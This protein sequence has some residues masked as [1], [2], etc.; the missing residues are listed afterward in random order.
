MSWVAVV[1]LAGGVAAAVGHL[2][3]RA[4]AFL[5]PLLAGVAVATGVVDGAPAR[6]AL[7][8]LIEPLSFV[9]LAVPLAV[10]LDAAG[11][12]DAVARRLPARSTALGLWVLGAA[13]VALVNLDAAV[14]LLTPVAIRAAARSGEDARAL[15][16]QPALLASLSSSWLPVSNLTNLIAEEHER[17]GPVAFLAHLGLPSLVAVAVGFLLWRRA[18]PARR[19]PAPLEP[20]PP[21]PAPVDDTAALR[22]AVVVGAAL[23]V[24]F[25]AG[26]AVGV[27]PWAVAA[28]VVV[29]LMVRARSVPVG[30]VPWASALVVGGLAVLAVAVAGRLDVAAVLGAG[31]GPGGLA[32]IVAAGAVGANGANNL[33]AFLAGLPHLPPGDG[34]RWA[35]LLGV[36]MGPTV[37]VTGSL[38]GLLWVDVARRS[39]LAVGARDYARA[40]LLVGVPA[41]AVATA[42]LVVTL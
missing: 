40:G 42:V 9:A 26:G 38:A 1:L 6:A 7:G 28:V 13:T 14:V 8:D 19:A 27:P 4:L 5:P 37:V 30:A 32:R 23:L 35:W 15:A 24:G 11:C 25:T 12:F 18:A 22:L 2:H 34:A 31:E 29:A 17:R 20:A 21:E 10:L 16:L 39:G 36:N 41:L 3:R 33:P